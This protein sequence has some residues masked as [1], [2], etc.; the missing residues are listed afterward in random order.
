MSRHNK[1]HLS[2]TYDIPKNQKDEEGCTR[3]N[4]GNVEYCK[5]LFE[6]I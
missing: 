6:K 5:Y 2:L 4:D 3:I 1:I